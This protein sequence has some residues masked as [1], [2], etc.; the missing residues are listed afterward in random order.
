MLPENEVA[1]K[2]QQYNCR[3]QVKNNAEKM[4]DDRIIAEQR[5]FRCEGNEGKRAI[6]SATE[7][8]AV[9]DGAV[10]TVMRQDIRNP[11]DPFQHKFVFKDHHTIIQ[12]IAVE[13]GIAIKQ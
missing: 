7:I 9:A 3:Q 10:K 1:E 6:A 8:F 5:D 2:Q 11:A 13:Q 4:M 12:C